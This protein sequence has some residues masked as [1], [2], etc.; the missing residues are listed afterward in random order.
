[1]QSRFIEVH[2]I[3]SDNKALRVDYTRIN[4][5][6]FM[7]NEINHFSIAYLTLKAPVTTIVI[8]FVICLWF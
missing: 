4:F 5:I 2:Y 8:C 7:C 1:M 3:G 6:V